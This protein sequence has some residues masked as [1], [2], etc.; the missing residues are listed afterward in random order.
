MSTEHQNEVCGL[1]DLEGV[2]GGGYIPQRIGF[3]VRTDLMIEMKQVL[4]SNL[5]SPIERPILG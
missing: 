1:A 4:E 3:G 5:R 2:V